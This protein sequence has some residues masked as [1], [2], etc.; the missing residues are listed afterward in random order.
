MPVGDG[1]EVGNANWRFRGDVVAKFDEHVAKSVPFYFEGHELCC[2]LSDYFVKDGSRVY[3]LGASTGGLTLALA[4]HHR[5]K[6]GA[7]FV[8]LDHEPEMV[9]AARRR[10]AD[11]ELDNASFEVADLA[12]AE[13]DPCDLVTAYYT[14]Q[15]V[16]P[17]VR[18]QVFDR[19]YQSLQWGGAFLL[20]EK[21]RG[22]DARFQDI[23]TGIYTD[24]KLARGYT[25]EEIVSKSRS[26]KGVLDCGEA[27]SC[28]IRTL[29]ATLRIKPRS[30][31]SKTRK[32]S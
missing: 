29:M 1:L 25:P 24:Y 16:R 28:G 15:F 22:A 20:F 21:V 27:A 30:M 8:G 31:A 5:Q 10:L 12:D 3:D 4:E 32:S 19:V 18:Q 11:A 23:A 14:I 17:S 13:L 6:E 9:D 7:S 26:L 2:S